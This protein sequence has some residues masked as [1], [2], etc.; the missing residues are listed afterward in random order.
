[1]LRDAGQK[2]RQRHGNKGAGNF[3]A[4]FRLGGSGYR[5]RYSRQAEHKHGIYAGHKHTCRGVTGNKAV[6]IPGV[7]IARHGVCILADQWLPLTLQSAQT[8]VRRR[9][10]GRTATCSI[11]ALP[12]VCNFSNTIV[13][14]HFIK[15]AAENIIFGGLLT[16]YPYLATS[17]ITGSSEIFVF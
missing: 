8:A 2:G 6:E 16:L 7:N 13:L 9:S 17:R 11:S 15:E 12:I 4:V 10:L 1:M 14:P 3:G 5:Q